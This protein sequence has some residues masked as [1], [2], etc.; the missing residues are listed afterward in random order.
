MTSSTHVRVMNGASFFRWLQAADFYKTLHA[1]AVATA[2]APVGAWLDVGC[3]PGL[4]AQ[5]ALARGYE[6]TGVDPSAAMVGA[7]RA[8]VPDARFEQD[9]LDGLVSRG[10][11]SQVV[12]AASLVFVLPDPAAG[13]GAL[14]RLVRPGGQLLVIETM[15]ALTLSSALREARG[16]HDAGLVLWGLVRGGRSVAPLLQRFAPPGLSQVAHHP[17]CGGLVGA[18][19]FTRSSTPQE[20][21][22]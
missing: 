13:L 2:P 18:W 3:G 12:S 9:T 20:H 19:S 8:A 7:A 11:T 15:P 14:W 16:T 4:V 10:V 5:L 6:V 17:L 1:E 21:H 22:P